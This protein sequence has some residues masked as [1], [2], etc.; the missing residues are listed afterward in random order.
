MSVSLVIADAA[1][2]VCHVGDWFCH[3]SVRKEQ[4]DFWDATFKGAALIGAVVGAFASLRKYLDERVKGNRAALL[5]AQKPFFESRQRVFYD[6]VQ[7]AST[8]ANHSPGSPA[9]IDAQDRFWW[10]FWG[11]L[12][13]VTDDDVSKAADTFNDLLDD[14]TPG[15][16]LLNASMDLARACRVS[17]SAWNGEKVDRTPPARSTPLRIGLMPFKRVARSPGP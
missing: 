15:V 2:H 11:T 1:E 5:E 13:M 4:A 14:A 8:I 3:L 17:L 10:I 9:R 16:A 6:L 12:P 7:A